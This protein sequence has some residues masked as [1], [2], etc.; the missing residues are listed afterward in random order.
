[1]R[2]KCFQKHLILKKINSRISRLVVSECA[3][4]WPLFLPV[5]LNLPYRQKRGHFMLLLSLVFACHDGFSSLAFPFSQHRSETLENRKELSQNTSINIQNESRGKIT[6]TKKLEIM[7]I[8]LTADPSGG[9]KLHKVL[10]M[11]F[12]CFFIILIN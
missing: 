2:E 6:T 3:I 8:I 4:F 11:F 7:T 1:M 9:G 12:F 5:E 10:C